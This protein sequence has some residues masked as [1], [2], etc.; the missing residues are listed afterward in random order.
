MYKITPGV[1]FLKQKEKGTELTA[2][3]QATAKAAMC[4]FHH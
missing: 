1:F 3:T 4:I 2:L